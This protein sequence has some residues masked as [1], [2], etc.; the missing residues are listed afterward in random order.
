VIEAAPSLGPEATR[1][2][3]ASRPT[4]ALLD[5]I[6]REISDEMR[7]ALYIV[8]DNDSVDALKDAGLVA[9]IA[10]QPA[11]LIQRA[12]KVAA[13][14]APVVIVH[15]A[16]GAMRDY[17]AVEVPEAELRDVGLP[18]GC[19]SVAGMLGYLP[20]CAGKPWPAD[21]AEVKATTWLDW[22][23][24]R[25]VLAVPKT[26]PSGIADVE[27][28]PF[29]LS[30]LPRACRAMVEDGACAQGVDVAYWAVPMLGILA[31]CIGNS[32]RALVKLGWTEPA[33]LWTA[34][35]APS[36][37]GKSPPLR[38]LLR[39]VKQSDFELHEKTEAAQ[40]RFAQRFDAWKATNPA[41][42]GP[43]P[44]PPPMLAHLIDDATFEAIAVRLRDN[45]RGL[46]LANDELAGFLRSFDKYRKGGGDEQRWLS[47][48]NADGIK[49]DRKSAPGGNPARICVRRA[50]VSIVGTIPP[51]IAAKYLGAEE[52][53]ASGLSPR[54]LVAAPPIVAAKWTDETVLQKVSSDYGRVI[55]TL[56]DLSCDDSED[57]PQS[58]PLDPG[59]RAEFIAY[60]DENGAT[61][62]TTA[63][64]GAPDLAAALSKLRGAAP[65][66]ALVLAL[67]RAAENGQA[68][69]LTSIDADSMRAGIALAQWFEGEARR[70][71]GQWAEL[72]AESKQERQQSF[73][74]RVFEALYAGP[75][76]RDALR[77]AFHRN[78]S[79]DAIG[80]ALER[81]RQLGLVEMTLEATA[82]RPRQIWRRVAA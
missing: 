73:D 5:D 62:F 24:A 13:L 80:K 81:L 38:E 47:I 30:A 79:S 3:A 40:E 34:I 74:D 35:V 66:L 18:P 70:L 23:A 37:A 48:H 42:R 16:D 69:L 29:P 71:Y 64:Q 2:T 4:A 25:S 68:E 78:V 11:R 67:A 44:E 6:R 52:Q 76:S 65:R 57:G 15:A 7:R 20:R 46:L 72:V 77:N 51:A 82:G 55:R 39:P 63:A 53:R 50:T 58:L 54:V 22:I 26:A 59:A 49:V 28:R 12:R 31:G 32:R 9:T 43:K 8:T 1:P 60:H 19:A 61:C 14:G 10:T 45:P 33:V 36:G 27:R 21:L 17:L 56:L 75:Q 41:K